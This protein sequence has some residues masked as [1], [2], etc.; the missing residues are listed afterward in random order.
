LR[1]P[2]YSHLTAFHFRWPSQ[3]NRWLESMHARPDRAYNHNAM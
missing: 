1:S 2:E 3:A